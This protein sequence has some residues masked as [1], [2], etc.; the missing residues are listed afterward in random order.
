MKNS[1]CS[2]K[3][4]RVLE[5]YNRLMS[6][7]VINKAAIAMEYNVNPR[8]I[9][10][11]IDAIREYYANRAVSGDGLSEIYYDRSAKGYRLINSKTVTLSNAELFSIIKILLESRAL[12]KPEMTA[13]IEKLLDACLPPAEKRKMRELAGNELYHYVEPRHRKALIDTVWTLGSAVYK[14]RIVNLDYKK[15]N[16]EI[17]HAWVKPVGIMCSEYYFYL[18]AYFEDKDKKY[19]GYPTIYRIDRIESYKIT[20][21]NFDIPYRDRFEEG[22]FRKRIPF[23]YGGPLRKETFIYD[24]PDINAVLDRLP[25]ARALKQADGS[26]LVTAEVYG[27]KGIK[28]WLRGQESII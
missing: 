1:D 18:I 13:V 17:T 8:S 28:L 25:T 21:D 16:G 9:Q 20:D 24:G 5:L 23:M 11:D 10:R 3:H 14:Q 2:K 15:A 22:E 4:D 27:E 7:E 19:P 12:N 26:Y 6:G